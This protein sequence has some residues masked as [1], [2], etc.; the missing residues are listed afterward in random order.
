MRKLVYSVAMSL[1]GYIAGP[2]GEF[3][4]ITP[5]PAIDFKAL[6][7]R[8]DTLLMGRKTYDLMRTGGQ[9]AASMGMKSVYVVSSTL[10]PAAHPDVQIFHDR[11]AETV[12]DLKGQPGKDIWLFGGG[13]LFRSM[14]DAGLVDIVELAVLPILLGSGLPVI[15]EGRRTHLHLE[16]SKPLPSG[17][18]LLK[19]SVSAAVE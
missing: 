6:F 14:I 5:D 9:T 12:A 1:D 19:Y 15:P 10:D 8:F 2:R 11:I 7:S 17:T 4:W 16:E 3:D 18:L 13:V